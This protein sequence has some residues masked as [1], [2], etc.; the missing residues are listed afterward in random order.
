MPKNSDS[1]IWYGILAAMC[2]LAPLVVAFV[3]GC[4]HQTT[5]AQILREQAPT[6]TMPPPV[7]DR[8]DLLRRGMGWPEPI[9]FTN[10]GQTVFEGNKPMILISLAYLDVM[11]ERQ[12]EI[13]RNQKKILD[14]QQQILEMRTMKNDR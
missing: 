10:H 13:L 7:S 2:M 6:I 4:N 8:T 5:Q 3:Q 9:S 12:E 11:Y 1:D 14:Q